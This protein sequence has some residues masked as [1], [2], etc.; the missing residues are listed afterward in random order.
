MQ[1]IALQF[2]F[3]M[4][5]LLL[6]TSTGMA[7]SFNY[8]SGTHTSA[9]TLT[10]GQNG[11][12]SSG[13]TLNVNGTSSSSVAVTVTGT[14]SITNG[15][16]IEQTGTRRA[17]ASGSS[18]ATLTVTN[19]ANA[20]I[21]AAAEDAIHMS[22]AGDTVTIYNS[23]TISNANAGG[24]QALDFNNIT[25]GGNTV[26]NYSTGIISSANGDAIRT[27][28]NGVVN[29]SGKIQGE[30][31]GS[32]GGGNDGIDAQTNTGAV[33]TNGSASPNTNLNLI[34]GAA[35]GISGGADTDKHDSGYDQPFCH[36]DHQLC[37]RH[38]PG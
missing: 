3:A 10:D 9:Q 5:G 11:S 34:E 7:D 26:N 21:S 2:G 27:G 35:H 17:I 25:T 29:N 4:A 30:S 33:I 38:Y 24:S 23:G 12:V 20:T 32:D 15:G 14:T 16:T 13:A 28:V 36:D 19:N 31:E 1:K 6:T 22:N 37:G 8:T 18:T